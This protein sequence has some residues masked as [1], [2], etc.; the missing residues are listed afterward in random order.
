[1][2]A[3]VPG[4]LQ[5]LD[6]VGAERQTVAFGQAL[7]GVLGR[8]TPADKDWC[9]GLRVEGGVPGEV[10]GVGV[11]LD[12]P[13][14]GPFALGKGEQVR[15][16]LPARVDDDGL[17][18]VPVAEEVR[19]APRVRP[20]ELPKP[21]RP[22]PDVRAVSGDLGVREPRVLVDSAFEGRGEGEAA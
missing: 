12:D 9:A 14:E 8:R 19:E 10:V 16:G 13:D 18:A 6:G 21:E 1:V 5:D 11:R 3:G 15:L 20:R 17:P 2:I 4:R 7:V 22:V